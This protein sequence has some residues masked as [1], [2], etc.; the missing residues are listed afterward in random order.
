LLRFRQLAD[1][2]DA[3]CAGV[4]RRKTF[5]FSSLRGVL[6]EAIQADGGGFEGF[7]DKL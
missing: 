5:G 3:G 7:L 6:D 1:R 2:N 4:R